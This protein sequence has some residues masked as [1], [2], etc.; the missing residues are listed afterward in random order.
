M[1]RPRRKASSPVPAP[2]PESEP[3]KEQEEEQEEKRT[4]KFKQQL[5]GRPGRPV[6]VSELLKR[7]KALHAELV[8]I[9]QDDCPRDS[10]TKVAQE[11]ADPSVLIHRDK[12]VKAWA[13]CC[14]VEVF[15][16]MAPDAPF[17]PSQLKE[18]FEL[19]VSSIIPA[20]ADPSDPYNDQH[21]RVLVSLDDLKT[22]VL[23]TDLP[24]ADHFMTRLF[25][26][27]FELLAEDTKP[28]GDES[29][30][31]NVE[32]HLTRL[33]ATL[34][35]ESET[36]PT[37]VVE[38]ILAQFLRTDSG[39]AALHKKGAN[40]NGTNGEA[41]V[42]GLPPAYSLAKNLCNTC[43]ERMA[44]AISQYFST[45]IV[46][47]SES[48]AAM[49]TVKGASKKRRRP[50]DGDSE[51]E[52]LA[53]G[54][55]IQD[56]KELAKAHKLLRE[57]WRSSPLSIQNVVPQLEAELS[58][59]NVDIR[60]IAVETVGD[61]I[62]GIGA[63]G[64]PDSEPM[65]PAVYPS[66][67]SDEAS[68][69]K[70]P[71]DV[72]TTPSSPRD[73][74]AVYPAAYSQFMDRKRDKS[75]Q[76]RAAFVEALGRILTT[77]AG[78][79]GL[80]NE[81]ETT[82][83]ENLSDLL[84]DTDDKVRFAAVQMIGR[85]S[86]HD[87]V[88]KLGGDGGVSD[89]GSVLGHAIDRLKDRKS[90]VRI[91]SVEVFAKI[92]GVAA[93][94]IAE[95]NERVRL[96]LGAIPT[97]LF[98]AFYLGKVETNRAIQQALFDSL[99]PLTYPRIKDKS[100]EKTGSNS[101]RVKDSQASQNASSNAVDVDAL[102]AQRILTLVRDL[103][104]KAKNAFFMLQNRQVKTTSLLE[105]FIK[106]CEE[107]NGGVTSTE[108][109]GLL[110]KFIQ[111]FAAAEADPLTASE[112]LWKF[113]KKHD[114][115]IYHLMRF[116]MSPE[117]D[118]K[119]VVN[120]IREIRKRLTEGPGNLASILPTIIPIIL[121]CS[122]IVYN[123]SHV[124]T[125]VKYARTDEDGLGSTA[126]EVL[127]QIAEDHPEVFKAH[128]RTMCKLLVEQK[129]S[130]GSTC[131][132]GTVQTL[133][134]CAS[135]AL[136]FPNEMPQDRDLLKSMVEYAL[137]SS[138]ADAAKYAVSVV[139][140]SED[141]KDMYIKQIVNGSIKSFKLGAEGSLS[142]LA[143]L[144]QLMLLAAPEIED[145]HDSI[146]TIAI[147]DVLMSDKLQP[148]DDESNWRVDVD[149]DTASK[150]WALKILANRLR[151]YADK[152]NG[153]SE[154]SAVI[155]MAK[156]VYSLLQK[157]IHKEGQISDRDVPEQQ[158]SRIRL[159][160][161]VLLLK[162]SSAS[163]YFDHL[164]EA[165]DFNKLALMTQDPVSEVRSGFVAALK[166]YLGKDYL[167][168]RFYTMTFLLAFEPT[169]S[170]KEETAKWLRAKAG[171]AKNSEHALELSFARFLS[172]LAHH[173]DFSMELEHLKD[174]IDYIL[175]YLKA[176]ATEKNLPLI[177]MIAQKVKSVQD[178]ISASVND[179]LYC[180]SDL[181]QAIIREFADVHGW[182][183]T[184]LSTKTHMPKGIFLPLRNHAE[185]QQI[186]AKQYCPEELLDGLEDHVRASLKSRKRRSDAAGL[187]SRKR[188]KPNGDA[189]K[190]SARPTA[191]TKTPKKSRTRDESSP[192]A[193]STERRRSG[194][195]SNAKSYAGMADSEDEDEE[196]IED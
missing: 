72:F 167:P 139:F 75:P 130:A 177:F 105:G 45:V 53:E 52:K 20:L 7:L 94:A 47:A 50:D 51:D 159:T 83:L 129:P 26:N 54:P 172:V 123:R 71:F 118:Y 99:L 56:M 70:K 176:V 67:S 194:R 92:W 86:F 131:E 39:M 33:L 181:A 37:D 3:E 88:R 102:R 43:T 107:Y 169:V 58:A 179:N 119:K 178:G 81:E 175:Y 77:S 135:F 57:L 170:T 133:K 132:E 142:K 17:T 168:Q 82:L 126:H 156:P 41:K 121:T 101:Q 115:R 25:L 55:S 95:G 32:Y 127:R 162:L 76:V 157:I 60:L 112:H 122:V 117:S 90:N 85:C 104:S 184:A 27:C 21:I 65:D 153:S 48:T 80:D 96:L 185:A 35:D 2:E 34:V 147:R 128:V 148:V 13:A 68:K 141:M 28:D 16:V 29:L 144:S 42:A 19:F 165:K 4:L 59:E 188:N 14:L 149:D 73:F 31:K 182:Q 6:P 138:P 89:E 78:G 11:L 152:L 22:I 164:L 196:M 46:D 62:S 63:A 136:K 134:A 15:R 108:K 10:V 93:G 192:A 44:R 49:K 171:S 84:Q 191:K 124:S 173:P 187:P 18:I 8:T 114:R 61:L 166:K 69:T 195:Q 193:M 106:Q 190:K 163:K 103:E 87:I 40:S 161:G 146:T 137:H 116:T 145:H 98:D 110:G 120:A 174:F 97:K 74:A 23:L 64:L 79:I 143:A 9:D 5:T 189:A 109:E 24:S 36:L 100:I 66:Q 12:G 38:L 140:A 113:A 150:I 183:L 186:A 154:D 111:S 155:E 151:G 160:A 125:I 158:R 180:L 91:A 1:P 30:S